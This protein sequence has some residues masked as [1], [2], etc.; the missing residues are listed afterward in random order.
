[1]GYKG[2]MDLEVQIKNPILRGL[3]DLFGLDP[4]IISWL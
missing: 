2:A 4:L 3:Q 1:M